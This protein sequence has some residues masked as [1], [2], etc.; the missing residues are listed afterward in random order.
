[1]KKMMDQIRVIQHGLGPIQYATARLFD[2]LGKKLVRFENTVELVVAEEPVR[3]DFFDVEPGQTRGLHQ[4]GRA[5]G[6]DGE[7]ISLMFR[8][9]LDEEPD[10]DMIKIT[11]RPDL[12]VSL[13]GANGDLATV[14]MAV[15][16]MKRTREAA[17]G[18]VT[19]RDLPI[20]TIS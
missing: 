10:G 17:P 3:T 16:A 1:V 4:T 8:A 7:F 13:Q 15:N 5:Y 11:G 2:T 9:A 6:E 19:M 12:T 14:A 20:V 18:L